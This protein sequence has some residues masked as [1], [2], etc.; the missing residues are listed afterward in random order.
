M[1]QDKLKVKDKS[2]ETQ[3][4]SVNDDP[5]YESAQKKVMDSPIKKVVINE[6]VCV[7]PLVPAN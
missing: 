3:I 6:T 4:N 5:V 2:H 1:Y 7:L